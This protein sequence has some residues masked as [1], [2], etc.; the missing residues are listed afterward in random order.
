M[1]YTVPIRLSL[2]AL[3]VGLVLSYVASAMAEP[4]PTTWRLVVEGDT[5]SQIADYNLS[6]SDCMGV[7]EIIEHVEPTYADAEVVYCEREGAR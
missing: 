6:L 1:T 5:Y 4:A 7:A 3:I 2:I